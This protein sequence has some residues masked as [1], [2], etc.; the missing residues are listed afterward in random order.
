MLK[1]FAGIIVSFFF[2]SV[3]S[4]RIVA[5]SNLKQLTDSIQFLVKQ[6]HMTGLMV[7]ISSADSVL[8]SGG[9]GYADFQ[10]ERK[11]TGK[12]LF[13]MASISKMF[14]SLAILQLVREGNIN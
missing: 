8:F 4:Q 1:F 3:Y 10:S 5:P 12:T 9:F 7:G 14:V 2:H 6:R 11:V 13:R